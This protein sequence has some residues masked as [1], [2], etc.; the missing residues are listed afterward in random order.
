MSSLSIITVPPRDEQSIVMSMSVCLSV[1]IFSELTFTE[2]SMAAAR[3]YV[4]L[5]TYGFVDDV[6]FAQEQMI[7]EGVYSKWLNSGQ[8]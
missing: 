8:H 5:P 3:S 6:M 1:S 2:L 4:M 7:Q